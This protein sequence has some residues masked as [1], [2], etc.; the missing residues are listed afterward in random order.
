MK[1]MQIFSDF[2][3]VSEV[4]KNGLYAAEIDWP[5]IY[6]VLSLTTTLMCTLLIVYRIV[7]FAHRLL[8]FQRII[9]AL[10]ESAMIYTLSLIVYLALVGEEY[11][12][13]QPRR[14]LLQHTLG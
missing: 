4:S 7:R 10:I 2:Q 13:W 3:G 9:S 14:P 1:A 11:D 5:L 6:A 12:G 8:L